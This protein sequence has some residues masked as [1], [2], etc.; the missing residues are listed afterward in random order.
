MNT[1]LLIALA[2][3][4][5][6]SSAPGVAALSQWATAAPA[7][8]RAGA[9][10]ERDPGDYNSGAHLYREF[11]LSCHGDT[12][13]GDGPV[14]ATLPHSPTNLT[15]LAQRNGGTFPR[16]EVVAVIEATRP[17]PAHA[18]PTMPNW[19]DIFSRLE[20]GNERAVRERIEALVMHIEMLQA[21]N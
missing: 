13:R 4:A 18:G 17:V 15:L 12:G 8:S 9:Q 21:K 20:R 10:R 3:L 11:C 7:P 14:A 6:T 2:L 19:R 1:H 16:Q 5:L